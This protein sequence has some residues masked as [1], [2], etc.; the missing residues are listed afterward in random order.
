MSHPP[1]GH[2]DRDGR[3]QRPV[4][5]ARVDA[6]PARQEETGEC[7]DGEVRSDNGPAACV[8]SAVTVM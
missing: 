7:R 1:S 2:S 6:D 8:A 4:S 3:Q 5:I